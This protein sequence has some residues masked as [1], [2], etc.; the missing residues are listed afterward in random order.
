V[1]GVLNGLA[2]SLRAAEV[3]ADKTKKPR[4]A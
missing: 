3:E 4:K 2:P 1:N